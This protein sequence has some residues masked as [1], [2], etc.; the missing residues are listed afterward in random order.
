MRSQP[1]ECDANAYGPADEE[2]SLEDDANPFVVSSTIGL[3]RNKAEGEGLR[4]G[5]GWQMVRGA[6]AAGAA[7]RAGSTRSRSRRRRSRSRRSRSLLL[8]LLCL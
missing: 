5:I 4:D 2:A 7:A 3:Q 1:E 8:M 6:A